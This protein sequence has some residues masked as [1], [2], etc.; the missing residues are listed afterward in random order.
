[1]Y[2]NSS[3]FRAFLS[4]LNAARASVSALISS[5]KASARPRLALVLALAMAAEFWKGFEGVESAPF[6]SPL[7]DLL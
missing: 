6:L 2:F 5:E 1:L 3:N 7:R 4:R